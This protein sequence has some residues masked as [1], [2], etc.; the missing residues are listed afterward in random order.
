MK[1]Y[2]IIQIIAVLEHAEEFKKLLKRNHLSCE[3]HKN[4]CQCSDVEMCN[5]A[6]LEVLHCKAS[7]SWKKLKNTLDELEDYRL[8]RIRE[9]D[10]PR[11]RPRKFYSL[12]KDWRELLD[13]LVEEEFKRLYYREY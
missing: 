4:Y 1:L 2:S 8:V 9:V 12:K 3:V 6:I 10:T 5:A 11:N 13:L 7:S